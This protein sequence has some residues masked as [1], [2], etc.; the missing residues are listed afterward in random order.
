M[1]K[2]QKAKGKRQNQNSKVKTFYFLIVIFTFYFLLFTLPLISA[3]S[4]EELVILY[5]GN[6][7]GMIYH[8]NCPI[9]PDGGAA[10][11]ATLV[12]ELRGK[13]PNLLLLDSGNF[14]AGGMYDN[15]SQNTQLDKTRSLINLQ[16]MG[17]MKYDAVALGEEEFN[18]GGDFLQEGLS[19]SGLTFLSSNFKQ[20]KVLPSMIK[21]IAG[22]KFGIIG[23]TGPLARQKA[24]GLEFGEPKAALAAQVAE[25][26]KRGAEII[27]L[28]TSMMED[29]ALD[30]LNNVQGVDILIMGRGQHNAGPAQKV[31]SGAIVLR[32]S[33]QGRKLGKI[34][35]ALK[36]KKITDYKSEE[37]RLSDSIAGDKEILKVLPQCFS[38]DNCQKTGS[39]GAC[40]NPGKGDAQ[41][42]FKQADKVNLIVISSPAC[43]ACYPQPVTNYLKKIIPGLAIAYEDY[44]D[45]KQA[46]KLVSD[47]KIEA[48]P[49]YLLG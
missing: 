1:K 9:E 6:T 16:A 44:P 3:V 30:L 27:L 37:I 17:L 7:H 34:T 2:R 32:P 46:E 18:F 23:L 26:K 40:A 49:A 25:L 13:Y 12:K 10:R 42:R 36:D 22:V 24:A 19:A 8:C 28:L 47:L 41:C 14:F 21:E 38:D 39:L 29:D 31:P 35:L 45:S 15:Y 4:A 5:T 43:V 48:L 20:D 33:W 11:R